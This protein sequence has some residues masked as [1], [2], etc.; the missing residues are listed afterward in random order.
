MIHLIA[1]LDRH[2]GLVLALLLLAATLVLLGGCTLATAAKRV[3]SN[4]APSAPT[5]PTIHTPAEQRLAQA[6][7][8]LRQAQAEVREAKQALD[9]ERTAAAQARIWWFAGIMG[10]IAL[11]AAGLAIFV[12]SVARWA[13][14]LA[15]AAAAVAALAIFAAWLLPWLWWIGAALALISVIGAI[16]YWRL[17]AKSRDQVVQAVDRIKDRVPDFKDTFRQV[18]DTDADLAIDAARRR[19]GLK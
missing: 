1:W 17:D 5:S 14:R 19:L 9:D 13:L 4:T 7:D 10:V 8:A 16:I 11:A 12:P 2:A 3:E 6:Q 18:I 15:L